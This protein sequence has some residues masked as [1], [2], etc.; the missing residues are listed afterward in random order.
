MWVFHCAPVE[1]RTSRDVGTLLSSNFNS[2]PPS[3]LNKTKLK[4][5][6]KFPTISSRRIWLCRS[7]FFLVYWGSQ[8]SDDLLW[9][10]GNLCSIFSP[11]NQPYFPNLITELQNVKQVTRT[12]YSQPNFTPAKKSACK[13]IFFTLSLQLVCRQNSRSDAKMFLTAHRFSYNSLHFLPQPAIFSQG[14]IRGICDIL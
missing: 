8:W 11:H 4:I 6:A 12:K 14:Y 10:A 5:S 13:T 1:T 9:K 7:E 2:P 3:S